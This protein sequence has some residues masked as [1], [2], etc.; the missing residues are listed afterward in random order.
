VRVTVTDADGDSA[1]T[2]KAIT[3]GS[4]PPPDHQPTAV[5]SYSPSAPTAGQAVSFDASAS[6]CDD[7]PCTYK[8]VD[9]GGDGPGGTDWALGS[10][11][12]FSYTFTGA[13]TKNVRLTV[14]DADGDSATTVKAIKVKGGGGRAARTAS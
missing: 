4:A 7:A 13:G 14:T 8:W 5:Y 10:G 1:T 6:A 12:T 11:K 3:V 9:D 2:M